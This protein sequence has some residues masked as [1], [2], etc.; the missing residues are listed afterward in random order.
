MSSSYSISPIG[1]L[2]FASLIAWLVH[3]TKMNWQI[4]GDQD[5]LESMARAIVAS[6]RFQE[7]AKSGHSVD[8]I[9]RRLNIKNMSARQFEELTGYSIPI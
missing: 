2:F 9:I 6:K 8:E 3:D 4:R 1:K 5:K 7:E